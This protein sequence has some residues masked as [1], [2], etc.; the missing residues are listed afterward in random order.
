MV[1][2]SSAPVALLAVLWEWVRRME[3]LGDGSPL[4]S[5][6]E[7]HEAKDVAEALLRATSTQL[8]RSLRR[9]ERGARPAAAAAAAAADLP[10]L[11]LAPHDGGW[12]ERDAAVFCLL[13]LER[14][15]MPLLAALF[16]PKPSTRR[17]HSAPTEAPRA[18]RRASDEE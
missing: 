18:A 5:A 8:S 14:T 4:L 12:E 3:P 10:L 2:S 15:L 9:T 6:K 13:G 17:Q 1:G 16:P 7:R 11:S